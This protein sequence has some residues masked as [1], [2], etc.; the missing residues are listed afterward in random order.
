[1]EALEKIQSPLSYSWG[2]VGHLMGVKNSDDLRKAHDEMQPSIVTAYQ[3]LGQSAALYRSLELLKQNPAIWDNLDNAQKRIIDCS[4][5][6][7]KSSGVA[8]TGEAKERFNQLQLEAAELST[9]FSNNVLDSTKA[10]KLRIT[11]K[12]ELEGLPESAKALAAQTAVA[13]GDQDAT[14][15]AGPWVITLDIP[16]YLPCMKYLK[17]R[18]IRETLYRAYVSR[19]S[20][21][22]H[23]NAPIIKRILQIKTEM[24]KLLGYDCFAD[25]SLAAKMAPS[26]DSVVNLIEMLREKSLP[27]AQR[28][29]QEVREFAAAQGC[30]YELQLWDVAFWSERLREAQYEYEEEQL[31]PYFALPIVLEGMFSLATRLFGVKIIRADGEAQVWH[32]DVMFFKVL[33][34]ETGEHIASFYLDAYSRPAEKRGGAWMDVCVGKSKALDRKPVAYLTCNGSPPVGSQPSLM[35]FREVETL[36]HEFGH[37]LQHML[38]KVEHGDAAGSKF[39]SHNSA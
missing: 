16:S 3:A 38:T 37:G 27:A 23:D 2:V 28:E 14:A 31:R 6:D 19:A 9:K 11:N 7:M 8:L 13:N 36:F 25:K 32:D 17:N 10:F 1:M 12:D 18:D 39:S 33:D 35:T 22:E 30:D 34:E 5:R 15:E 21:G 4:I 29:L 26:V 24:A 20:E